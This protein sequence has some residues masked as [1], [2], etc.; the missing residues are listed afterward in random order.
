MSGDD[1]M[2][3]ILDEEIQTGRRWRNVCGVL[4]SALYGMVGC[5]VC[6]CFFCG[7]GCQFPAAPMV[8]TGIKEDVSK[9]AIEGRVMFNVESHLLAAALG[10]SPVSYLTA[11]MCCG[12]CGACGPYGTAKLVALFSGNED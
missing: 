1:I 11:C 9:M 5:P 8:P 7:C 4:T 6:C 3:K 10:C 12:L 2:D